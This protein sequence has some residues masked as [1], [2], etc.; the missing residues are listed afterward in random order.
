MA[1][2]TY[3][4]SLY[5][6]YEE[7]VNEKN[8]YKK[9]ASY[10]KLAFEN[11][12]KDLKRLQANQE[13]EIKAAVEKAIAPIEQEKEQ[14]KTVLEEAYQEIDRLK[15]LHEEFQSKDE[16]I[17]EVDKLTNQVNK[18]STNSGI[19]TSKEIKSKKHDSRVNTYNHRTKGS[20]KSGGQ[21]GHKGKTL[22]KEVLL[23]KVEENNIKVKKIIHYING[24]N[25]QEDTVKYKI[26]INVDMYVEEHIFKHKSKSKNVLPKEYYSD[27]TYDNSIK[28]VIVILGNY[29]CLGYSKVCELLY[30]FSRG[31]IDISQGT[32]DNTYEDFSD[33]A[34]ETINN[35]TNN[36][37]NG[38]WQHTD[39][40]T[41]KENGHDSYYRGY[42]NG[43]NVL[44][45]YHDKKGDTPIK[46][47]NILPRFFGTII[48]DHEKGIF[49][50]GQNNQDCVIH[51]GRYCIEASQNVIE[52][53]WQMILY[54]FLLKLERQ[55]KI[56]SKFGKTSFS[57]EEIKNIEDEYDSIIKLGEEQNI[58]IKSSYWREK[59]DTLLKRLK[60]YRNQTLFFIHDF[61]ISYDNNYMERLLRMIKGKTKVSGGFRSRKGGERF[62]KIMSI[63]KTAKL[64]E[65]N[66]FACIKLIFEGKALF[67]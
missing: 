2:N 7:E 26:G 17:Y 46:D 12:Q 43:K 63:I 44:Y 5:E 20:K 66:P 25:K 27:V 39:E 18:D 15:S 59:E 52:T 29:Y 67:A 33:K 8:K 58:E 21:V 64:R 42:A 30:D 55:R 14:L 24:S 32:I 22:T 65:K 31:I 6:M 35:I 62:G 50:Y 23:K 54:N 60:K 53:S 1:R 36:I 51:T 13:I 41:T 49:K 3:S 11:V 48:S 16:L 34:D 57:K 28:S 61:E 47:D 40:T 4:N 45:R 37:I 10:Y 56:L 19:P 38:K 9:E